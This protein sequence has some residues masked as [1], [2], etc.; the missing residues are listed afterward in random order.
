MKEPQ[1]LVILKQSILAERR[2]KTLYQALAKNTQSDSVRDI[3][4]T[5][6]A[7]EQSHIEFLSIHYR[8]YTDKGL[9]LDSKSK[10]RQNELADTLVTKKIRR[11]IDAAG[12][13]A[14]ALSAAIEL[15]KKS[16][17]LCSGRADEASDV[18]EGSVY[19][20]LAHWERIHLNL[21]N[22]INQD[23]TESIW[24]DNNFWPF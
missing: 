15:E 18:S 23:I 13:E 14:A 3:A 11:E 16:L 20:M 2:A 17:A 7:E 8:N 21:L 1:A 9:F 10:L 19:T 12:Y 4:K 22:K 5:L 6:M 24:H